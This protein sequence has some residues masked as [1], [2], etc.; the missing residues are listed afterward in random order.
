MTQPADLPQIEAELVMLDQRRAQLL[1]QAAVLRAMS[2]DTALPAVHH[3]S[4]Q[5]D[6][7]SL[8]SSLFRGRNDV[9]P[10]RFESSKTGKS[11]YAPVCRNEWVSGL[12]EK[13]RITCATCANRAFVPVEDG[14]IHSHLLGRDSEHPR[15]HDFTAGV[16]PLLQDDTCWF[17]AVDFDKQ[18]WAADALAFVNTC[19]VS[20]VS[21]AL[22]RSR[23]GNGGHVWIFFSEPVPAFAARQLGTAMLTRAMAQRPELGFA[24]YD[25]LFPNQDTLP[26]GGFGNLIALP[27]QGT[28]RKN[29]NSV[30]VDANLLPWPDQWAFLSTLKRISRAMLEALLADIADDASA[31]GMP[32]PVDDDEPWRQPASRKRTEGPAKGPLP[33]TLTLT[34]G[35][36]I[37]IPKDQLPAAVRNQVMRLA[38]FAN[39]AFY[40]AQRMR[41]STYDKPRVISCAEDGAKHLGLPRGCLDALKVLLEDLGIAASIEDVRHPGAVIDVAFGGTLRPDQAPAAEAMLKH[42]TGVLSAST[43]FG[44]TVLAIYLLAQRKAN[45]LIIVH[46]KQLLDQWRAALARFLNLDANEIGQLGGGKRNV[47]GSIDVAMIQSLHKGGDVDDVID[48]YGHVIVDE[49]HHISAVSFEQVIRRCKARYVTGLSATLQRKDGH[50]PIIFMQCGPI[51]HRSVD[52]A[53]KRGFACTGSPSELGKNGK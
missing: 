51:R 7:I 1:A 23:S 17:L 10:R 49:C 36:Q 48:Q 2:G 3:R 24:S 6:K 25:R 21:V 37:Y 53:A 52:S 8:F 32:A 26:K 19:T 33:A 13:P 4:P 31:L 34:L 18:D 45:T 40:E 47:T 27:L 28:P 11:G 38:A 35:D 15:G 22:E 50:Q 30:F 14:V 46:R 39:P 42:D 5:A 16:Y 12:C 29:G 9:F 20:G 44:K 41:M 43:A